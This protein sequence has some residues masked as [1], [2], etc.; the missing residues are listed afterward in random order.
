[1]VVGGFTKRFLPKDENERRPGSTNINSLTSSVWSSST[2]SGIH[3][4]GSSDNN[5]NLIN[6]T[7]DS[8]TQSIGSHSTM[9]EMKDDEEKLDA[10][11]H[12]VFVTT[13][14]N[15]REDSPT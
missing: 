5:T 8:I 1:M 7:A 4:L 9:V 3:S 13:S 12:Q 10:D 11:D 2:N 6:S 14:P 15:E